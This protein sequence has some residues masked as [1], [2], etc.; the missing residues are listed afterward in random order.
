MWRLRLAL[1][2]G[3][4]LRTLPALARDFGA[5]VVVLAAF[6][7]A[8]VALPQVTVPAAALVLM[9]ILLF[10]AMVFG[11]DSAVLAALVAALMA[12]ISPLGPAEGSVG[13]LVIAALCGAAL[14]MAAL[15]EELRRRRAEAETAHLRSDMTARCA[16][17]RVEAARRELR[18]AEARLAD[19]ERRAARQAAAAAARDGGPDPALDCAFR[20]EGGI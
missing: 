13:L 18:G 6:A 4:G 11:R 2:R 1:E 3:E 12:R 7:I 20:S 15:L 19:V 10:A 8:A 5:S 9:P 17:E 16:A 14:V